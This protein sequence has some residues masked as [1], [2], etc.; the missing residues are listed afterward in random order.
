MNLLY[1]HILLDRSGSMQTN[2]A[3]AIAAFNE[4]VRVRKEDAEVQTRISLTIFDSQ[5]TDVVFD[6]IPAADMPPLTE[7]T[8]IPRG[9]T[10][11][12]D[13]IG[14]TVAKMRSEDRL[15]GERTA[16]VILTD[17]AEN[18][19]TEYR[20]ATIKALLEDMQKTEEW[21]VLYLGADHDAFQAGADIGTN[22]GHTMSY[23]KANFVNASR[24]A[25]RVSGAYGSRSLDDDIPFGDGFTDQERADAMK[26]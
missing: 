20:Q 6:R 5:S 18:A 19:S 7:A 9:W 21:L 17:G 10:P 24:S 3:E 26:K 4:Y 2:K 11:L 8:F 14:R 22:S 1:A 16:L 12:F 23:D 13:A 25:S 15:P